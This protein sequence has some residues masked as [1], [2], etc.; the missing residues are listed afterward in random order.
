MLVYI[1]FDQ[2]VSPFMKFTPRNSGNIELID[3]YIV[4]GFSSLC[5]RKIVDQQLIK[6]IC[7]YQPLSQLF[8]Q[9]FLPRD[10]NHMKLGVF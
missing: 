5:L 2:N 10:H 1:K 9:G 8:C 6:S 4:A 7:D 3:F